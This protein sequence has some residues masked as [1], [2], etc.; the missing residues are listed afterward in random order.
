MPKEENPYEIDGV[1]GQGKILGDGTYWTQVG[2][3]GERDIRRRG[4]K[5]SSGRECLDIRKFGNNIYALWR[6]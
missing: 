3:H 5:S 6:Y 4:M 2:T 1:P